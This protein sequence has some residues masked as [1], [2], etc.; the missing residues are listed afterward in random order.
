[1]NR[2]IFLDRDG[3]VN[4]MLYEPDGNIMTP[5]NLEQV[6]IMPKVRE[7][8]AKLKE[9]GFKIIVV[10]NQPGVYFG[11]LRKEKLDEINNFLKKELGIDE[12]YCCIH[13][14][15]QGDCNCRKPKTG[16]IEMAAKDFDLDVKNSY[17][18]GDNLSD[19]KT[20]TNAGVKK[21]FRIGILREDIMELEHEKKIYPDFTLPDLVLV[22]EKIKKLEE[23]KLDKLELGSGGKPSPGYLH[24]DI[25]P[26]SE[27]ELDFICNPWEIPLEEN[28]LSEV[29]ALG[30]VEHFRYQDAHKTFAHVYKLLKKGGSFLFDVP[31]MKV[32]SEYLYNLTHGMQEKNP[33]RPEHV[34]ATTYGWQRWLGDEHKSGWTRDD[35]LDAIKKAGFS[36]V[37][38]GVQIFTSKGIERGRFAR[39][40]D[41]HLYIKATK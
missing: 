15:K 21:T 36:S 40:E 20:G 9:L 16:L 28:S 41:A 25:T 11:Y 4:E 26:L 19:I 1:M 32:W 12:I 5:A 31:D 6:K 38:E 35:I 13:H 10:T 29:L 18:V 30:V 14:P 17:M 2:A 34:W 7:G 27:V 23:N 24:Q 22:S 8:I 37:E 3:V 39:K 33:F